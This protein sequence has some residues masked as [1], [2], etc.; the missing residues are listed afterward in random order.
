MILYRYLIFT[1]RIE[2]RNSETSN[3]LR[4]S[5]LWRFF[6]PLRENAADKTAK[7]GQKHYKTRR[8]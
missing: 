1:R 6:C 7:P 3:R 5:K 2:Q 4:F 8:F